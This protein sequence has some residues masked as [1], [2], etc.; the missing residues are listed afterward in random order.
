M[1]SSRKIEEACKK[2]IDFIWLLDG[3]PAP[4]HT[5][6]ATFRSGPCKDAIEDLFYQHVLYLGEIGATD[7]KVGIFDGTKIESFANKYT[8]V[9]RGTVEKN[10]A[11]LIEKTKFVFARLGIQGDVTKDKLETIV[12]NKRNKMAELQINPVCGKGHRKSQLQR[13][14]EEL[15]SILEKWSQYEEHL[16]IMGPNRNSYSKTDPD[17]T[18]QRMKD[19]H[20]CSEC[21]RSSHA[22]HANQ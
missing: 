1:Y 6:I 15:S 5:T 2:R 7:Y 19:D 3:E 18:F 20:T 16:R 22:A 21:E 17:A 9:W 4:D 8:F 10:M 11:K 13:D 14:C 12:H